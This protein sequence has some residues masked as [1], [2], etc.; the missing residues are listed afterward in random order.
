MPDSNKVLLAAVNSQFIHSNTAVYYLRRILVRDGF[1]ADVKSFSIND[2]ILDILN[3]ILTG[4]PAVICFSC[5]IWNI[6]LIYGLCRDI[7]KINSR[8]KIVL[9]GPEV[10]YESA[11]ALEKSGAD[12][13]IRGE[14]E[15]AILGAVRGLMTGAYPDIPGCFYKANGKIIDKGITKIKDLETIITPFTDYMMNREKGKLIYYEASRG[16]PF[17]CIYCLSSANNGVRYF[18]LERVFSD[19][20]A[21]LEYNPQIIKFTDRSFNSN[22]GRTLEILAFIG[23]TETKTCFHL[24]IFPA[25]L[26]EKIMKALEDMPPGKVQLEAGIQS[27]NLSTLKAS[28]R[29]QDPEKALSNMRRL[30]VSGNMHIHLD[31]IAGLPYEGIESFKTSFNETLIT[32]PHMLQVGF[33]KLLKGTAARNV[34]GYIYEE[35]PPYEVLATP[36]LTFGE[37][38]QIKQISGCI[39]MFHNTGRFRTFLSYMYEKSRNPY[40]FYKNLFAYLAKKKISLKGISRNHKYEAL[41]GFAGDDSLAVEHLRYDFMSSYSSKDIPDFLGDHS[42]PKEMVFAFL[43]DENNCRYFFPARTGESPK[44]LYKSCNIGAFDFGNGL[45]TYLFKYFARDKVTGL[46]S[47]IL[48]HI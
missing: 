26:T 22:E 4:K 15:A 13:I 46:F 24:E 8:I 7:K 23:K 44:K 37:L 40:E 17:N 32:G 42:F 47:A 38:S 31:L 28:G 45:E 3:E 14:G 43:K 39:D 20:N 18:P 21:I 11:E 5:Y 19:L 33:L 10:T 25:G 36:W 48:L 1:D 34:D 9:G 6:N 29:L 2:E 41:A 16:C 30:L 27:V 12:L 35:N